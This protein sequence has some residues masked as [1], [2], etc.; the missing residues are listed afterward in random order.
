LQE[1]YNYL[2]VDHGLLPFSLNHSLELNETWDSFH[3]LK[4]ISKYIVTLIKFYIQIKNR[5][6]KKRRGGAITDHWST[7]NGGQLLNFIDKTVWVNKELELELVKAT[8]RK[9]FN[10]YKKCVTTIKRYHFIK[11]KNITIFCNDFLSY[12]YP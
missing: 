9:Y 6:K 1:D 5:Y 12:I 4:D 8:T 2:N 7:E 3:D 11:K 10:L